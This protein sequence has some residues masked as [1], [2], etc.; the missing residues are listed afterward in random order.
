MK[1]ATMALRRA[2]VALAICASAAI[3]RSAAADWPSDK[4]GD[5]TTW[6]AAYDATSGARFIP[7]QLILPSRWSGERRIELPPIASFV[8]PDG[9]RWK[10]PVT[11]TDVFTEAPMQAYERSR[12]NKREGHVDQRF[13]VRAEQDGLGRVYDSRFGEIRCV[14]EIKFPL[15]EWNQSEVRRNEF[16]CKS[17]RGE[18]KKRVN[19]ITIEKIDFPCR[20]VA[21]CIQF[22]WKHEIEGQAEPAD[23]RRYVFAPG[24]G[25]ITHDRLR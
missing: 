3:D 6:D 12:Y 14:G 11:D 20:G 8:D 10:G 18:P 22:T 23:Y 7:M 15:G 25:E 1:M 4:L 17:A 9:D 2:I 13:A 21:H 24:A 16:T 5:A 19:T